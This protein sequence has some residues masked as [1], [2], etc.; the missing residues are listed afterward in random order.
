VANTT[1]L[2][3]PVPKISIIGS[4]NN[5]SIS[6]SVTL[7][8][9]VPKLRQTGGS[10]GEAVALTLPTPTLVVKGE[11][12]LVGN[13][14]LSLPVPTLKV[15]G[16]VTTTGTVSLIL[17]VPVLRVSSPNDVALTL[18]V[19]T[20]A[21]Q[22][23]TGRVGNVQLV[24]PTPTFAATGKIPFTGNVNLVLPTPDMQVTGLVGNV[25]FMNNTLRGIA[26]AMD[27]Y[28]GVIGTCDLVLP[29]NPNLGNDFKGGLQIEG[30]QQ[31]NGTVALRL[32]MLL[33]Q[34]TGVTNDVVSGE[35]DGDV[36][37]AIVMQ[38]QTR[39]LWQ[40]TN[41]PF[42]SM[43]RFNGVQLGASAEGLFVLAGDTD[44][45]AVIQAAAR[46]GITDFGTS[47]LKRI[48]KCYV[49]LRA[50]GDMV[51]RVLTDQVNVRDYLITKYGTAGLHG[52]HTR[53]GRGVEA[54]Y[55]QF[56]IRNTLGCKFEFN[57]IE[58]KPVRLRRRIGGGDA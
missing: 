32:P 43:A 40:Y 15:K 50:D 36:L 20:F 27:G 23:F 45:G 47:Y 3:L 2:L 22:G 58:L 53:I 35:P 26:L 12:A 7:A 6:G 57:A 24:L 51:I 48:D 9:P 39:M 28:T 33:L 1:N 8:L 44:N 19:P 5:A 46:V 55:W 10:G 41:W 34:A 31:G 21:A 17:P 25:G 37:S 56:E 14:V 42:N 38:T 54:R 30:Y 11:T 18:P 49:G 4:V 13:V 52:N 29:V 16:E